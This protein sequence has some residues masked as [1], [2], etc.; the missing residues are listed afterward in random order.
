MSRN[1]QIIS[2]NVMTMQAFFG[3]LN[4]KE[5]RGM[6]ARST[7]VAIEALLVIMLF[8]R[9]HA[10]FRET[11]LPKHDQLLPPQIN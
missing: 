11:R 9:H 2:A 3:R 4:P 1:W 6:K 10:A 8:G 7:I 5:Q